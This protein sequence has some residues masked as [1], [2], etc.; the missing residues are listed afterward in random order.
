MRSEIALNG[1]IQLEVAKAKQ[2]D[3]GRGKVRI[4]ADAMKTVGVSIGDIIEIEGKRKTA[5]VVWPAYTEDQGK[6]I[7][8]MDDLIRKNASVG[9]GEKVTIRKAEIKVAASVELAPLSSG[10]TTDPGFIDLMK[11]R[12][13]DIPLID[14]DNILIPC[15]GQLIPFVVVRTRPHGIVIITETTSVRIYPSPGA[16][17]RKRLRRWGWL[18]DLKEWTK[19]EEVKFII[20]DRGEWDDERTAL[21]EASK[22]AKDSGQPVTV[23]V[24]LRAEGQV[25]LDERV[26]YA[27]VDTDG[28]VEYVYDEEL[29]V[30]RRRG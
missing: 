11:R 12:L 15:L 9:L 4:D 27:Q 8:G 30:A 6:D 18:V 16:V 1:E 7:I 2:R 26:E 10:I 3:V 25:K 28:D 20:P 17:D 5:A 14:G 13:A 19:A 22:L 29:L 21:S 24:G 23:F